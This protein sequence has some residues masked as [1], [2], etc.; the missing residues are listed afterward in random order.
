M[1]T[2]RSTNVRFTAATSPHVTW[3]LVVNSAS[4]IYANVISA[5]HVCHFQ[6]TYTLSD[7][8]AQHQHQH[9]E[10]RKARHCA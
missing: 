4:I 6:F 7:T 5:E 8:S 10:S 2:A 3:Y 1:A 9:H